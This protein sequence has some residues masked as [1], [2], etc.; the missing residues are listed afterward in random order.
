MGLTDYG[1][2]V[3]TYFAA[4]DDLDFAALLMNTG[5]RRHVNSNYFFACPV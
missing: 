3:A 5:E 4:M 1:V 2:F